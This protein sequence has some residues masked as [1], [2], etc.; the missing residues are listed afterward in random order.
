MQEDFRRRGLIATIA[1]GVVTTVALPIAR[2]DAPAFWDELVK[3]DAVAA[4]S[5]AS[6]MGISTL[7]LLWWRWYILAPPA[8]AVTAA[9]I[10]LGWGL[11]Q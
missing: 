5:L 2:W 8:A 1:L 10:I 11:A 3:P 9:M 6:I 7:V 4:I